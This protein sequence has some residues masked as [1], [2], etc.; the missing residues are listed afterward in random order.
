MAIRQDT[1]NLFSEHD[2]TDI[3]DVLIGLIQVDAQLYPKNEAPHEKVH[4][5]TELL[6]QLVAVLEEVPGQHP[7]QGIRLC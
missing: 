1:F 3:F 2:M 7:G 5:A 4:E 6:H